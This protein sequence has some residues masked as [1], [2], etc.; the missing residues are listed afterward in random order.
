[1]NA[2]L[3]ENSCFSHYRHLNLDY[4]LVS[5]CAY[6]YITEMKEEK[7]E[8]MRL[9]I[10]HVIRNVERLLRFFSNFS[11]EFINPL[12]MRITYMCFGFEPTRH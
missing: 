2:T 1:M 11:V 5:V 9:I 10:M 8:Y 4:R 6:V 12:R 7:K 3:D